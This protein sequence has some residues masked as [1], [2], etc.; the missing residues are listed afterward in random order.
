M[1]GLEKFKKEKSRYIR[2]KTF[3]RQNQRLSTHR[4]FLK[5]L[6][7]IKED[8]KKKITFIEREAKKSQMKTQMKF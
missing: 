5:M 8:L 1:I 2:Q 7:R 4:D 3:K 6:L